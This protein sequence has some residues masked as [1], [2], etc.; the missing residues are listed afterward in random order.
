[1]RYLIDGHNLIAQLPDINIEDDHDEAELVIKLR[2]FC[3]RTRKQVTVV[4]DG[5]LPGGFSP[6]LS[7]STVTVKFA[8]AERMTADQ[9]LLGMIRKLKNPKGY[10][11]VSSDQEILD[12][13]LAVGM[14]ILRIPQFIALLKP[15]SPQ[16]AKTRRAEA[17]KNNP[18]MSA[19]EVEEW[20]KIFEPPPD[21]SSNK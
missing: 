17:A 9:V 18:Q 4:F 12:A 7:N 8:S 14:P 10:T 20:L 15:P 1:M 11:L 13:A 3:V 2:G 19:S 21:Q 16:D 6:T 5:G